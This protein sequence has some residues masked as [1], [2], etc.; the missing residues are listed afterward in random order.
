MIAPITINTEMI[1]GQ[2]IFEKQVQQKEM[3]KLVSGWEIQ[4]CAGL[5]QKI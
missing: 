2:E 4:V 3:K 1:G 5:D